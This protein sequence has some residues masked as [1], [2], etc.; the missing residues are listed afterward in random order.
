MSRRSRAGASS[1]SKQRR[2][3]RG[4]NLN[5]L[6]ATPRSPSMPGGLPLLKPPY[7]R[8]TAINMNTGEHAWMTPAGNGDR[9]R[10]LPQLKPL[11]LPP[12]GGDH[13]T[14]G[15]SAHQDARSSIP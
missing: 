10:N 11:N 13:S 14:A 9:Y 5:Y 3:E 6:Q 15:A 2:P 7:S 1:G 8:I 4:G 12:V